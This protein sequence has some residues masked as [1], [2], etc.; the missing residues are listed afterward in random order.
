MSSNGS[1]LLELASLTVFGFGAVAFLVLALSYWRKGSGK[2]ASFRVFT[3][4]CAGSFL[5]SVAS[6]LLLPAEGLIRMLQSFCT[7]LL[8]P[9]MLHVVVDIPRS[10]PSFSL[11]FWRAVLGVSYAAAS[12]LALGRGLKPSDELD[13]AA[14]FML[15]TIAGLYFV[16]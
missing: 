9:L 12:A 3:V 8:P 2:T 13:R 5:S 4:I 11:Q 7:G 10:A 16:T 14:G 1:A 6:A 15:A